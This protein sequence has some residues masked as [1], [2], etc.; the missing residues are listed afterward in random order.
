MFFSHSTLTSK[1]SKGLPSSSDLQRTGLCVD[2]F[3]EDPETFDLLRRCQRLRRAVWRAS[4][5]RR[6]FRRPTR[7]AATA[8]VPHGHGWVEGDDA[9][10]N[11]RRSEERCVCAFTIFVCKTGDFLG[12]GEGPTRGSCGVFRHWTGIYSINYVLIN[13]IL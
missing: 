5:E 4:D 11:Q 12:G 6:T 13:M 3:F 10:E 7:T 1:S 2:V 8:T 9:L